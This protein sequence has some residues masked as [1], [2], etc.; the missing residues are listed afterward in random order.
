MWKGAAL[1]NS[2]F[3]SHSYPR[4]QSSICEVTKMHSSARASL[5]IP[6]QHQSRPRCISIIRPP[7]LRAF[8][9]TPKTT[10]I[11]S[12]PHHLAISTHY[13]R[14]FSSTPTRAGG[15]AAGNPYPK[16]AKQTKDYERLYHLDQS[17]VYKIRLGEATAPQIEEKEGMRKMKLPE[18]VG[19]FDGTCWLLF[20]ALC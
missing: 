1:N 14:S 11:H 12:R 2:K 16:L 7:I 18:D 5:S 19:L 4:L 8:S 6:I 15:R 20:C 9:H 3:K 13:A 17:V 10:A